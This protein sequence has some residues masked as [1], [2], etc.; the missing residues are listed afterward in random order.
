MTT[1]S[2]RRWPLFRFLADFLADRFVLP[3][4]RLL[5]L[6]LLGTPI[7]VIG[8][9]MG[10]GYGAF[11][12]YNG[13]VCVAS[14]LDWLTLPKRKDLELRRVLPEQSDIGQS[15]LV[16]VEMTNRSGQTVSYVLM[17]DLPHSF[18]EAGPISGRME[19]GESR[20][21]YQTR[22]CERGNYS[23]AWL[24]LR[25]SG[26]IGLWYRQSRFSFPQTIKIYPDLSQVRGYLNSLQESLIVDGKKILRRAKAGSEFHAIREYVPDDDPRTIN[27]S[28]S[29][30]SRRL[31]TNQYRPEHGKVITI[32]VD[33]GRLMG[34]ELNNQSRLDQSLE[35]ALTLAAVALRQGDQVAFLAYSHEIKTYIPPG[36]GMGHLHTILEATYDL[37]H[38]FVEA[39]PAKALEFMHRQQKRRSLMVLFSDMENYLVEDLLASYL[40]KMRRSHLFL[41]LSQADPLLHEWTRVPVENSRLA[42]IKSVAQRFQL[43]RRAFQQKMTGAGIQVLDVPADQLTLTVINAYLEIKAREAL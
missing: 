18:A 23:F 6:L 20:I 29:A 12:L 4:K 40:W 9:F 31:M 21:A 35:S 7:A 36:R 41:L 26:K 30:R 37:S 22:G 25:W 11:W 16:E 17:D 42:Y 3:T 38:D 24:Y 2:K 27:W 33:C 43:D 5:V 28:A 13:L 39:D 14:V 15:F 32:L 10:T 34:V 1:S 8:F 19:S